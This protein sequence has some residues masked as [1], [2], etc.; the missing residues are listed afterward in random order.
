MS[1]RKFFVGRAIGVAVVLLLIAVS[2]T[3]RSTTLVQNEEQAIVTVIKQ[4]PELA[5]YKNSASPSNSIQTKSQTD[6]WSVAF[7]KQG[8]DAPGILQ[9]QCYVVKADGTVTGTGQYLQE[10]ALE[11]DSLNLENC[12]PE[13]FSLR[14]T[15]TPA[16]PVI[17]TPPVILPPASPA[18][19]TTTSST[20]TSSKCYIGGCSSQLCTDQPGAISTCIYEESYACYKAATCERQTNNQ[21]GWTETPEL[22]ACI[23]SA[24][25]HRF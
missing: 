4:Y 10:D 21:C 9:A 3:W 24:N 20:T 17:T 8:S 15:S 23:A 12:A 1:L 7:I 25:D 22:K 19:S 16:T 14:A 18:D 2:Y 13:I 5:V 11:V 6:G